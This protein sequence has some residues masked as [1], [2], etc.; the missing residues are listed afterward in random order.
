M[1]RKDRS[2]ILG[3]TITCSLFLYILYDVLVNCLLSFEIKRRTPVEKLALDSKMEASPRL[4]L[5]FAFLMA[6]QAR[7]LNR[8]H[9]SIFRNVIEPVLE[10][11]HQI[12]F[13]IYAEDDED[14]W[15]YKSFVAE[16][17]KKN[18]SIKRNSMARAGENLLKQST[19][20]EA[21]LRYT[22]KIAQPPKPS[23]RCV[24]IL[25]K[26]Y[27]KSV[28]KVVRGPKGSYPGEFLTQLM[29][30]EASGA[31][32]YAEKCNFDVVILLRPDVEYA[33][34]IPIEILRRSSAFFTSSNEV[35]T[36]H[37]PAWAPCGGF[38]DRL[39]ISRVDFLSSE[40]SRFPSFLLETSSSSFLSS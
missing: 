34:R 37:V 11:K 6:G 38:N 31:L 40:V 20:T 23:E 8:T 15:Q 9:C 35:Y 25:S 1:E 19:S 32:M 7:T 24:N 22:L 33:N 39:M 27:E 16:I 2:R 12:H 26:K 17:T 4:A 28:D 30:R 14:V 10:E 13:F 5:N 21:S 3:V 29:Q 36:V 18:A